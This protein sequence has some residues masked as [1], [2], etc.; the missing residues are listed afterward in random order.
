MIRATAKVQTK[1]APAGFPKAVP[2]RTAAQSVLP[3]RPAGACACGGGCPVRNGW[4]LRRGNVVGHWKTPAFRGGSQRTLSQ[5]RYARS[6]SGATLNRNARIQSPRPRFRRM[7]FAFSNSEK[8]Y[9]LWLNSAR[10]SEHR[11]LQLQPAKQLCVRGDDDGGETHCDRAN[12]HG[13]IESPVDENARCH[14]DG[15]KVIGGRPN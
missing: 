10:L 2:P 15:D 7:L 1:A 6:E 13:Q 5:A 11:A 9:E 8:S 14:R 12:A 3:A 4:L